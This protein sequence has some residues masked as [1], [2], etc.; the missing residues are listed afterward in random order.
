MT[1]SRRLVLA[2]GAIAATAVS[3]S[4][5][6][7]QPD[8]VLLDVVVENDKG[9]PVEGL[10]QNDFEI[11]SDGAVRPI[12][13]FAVNTPVCI[14]AVIDRSASVSM[15]V[16]AADE[17]LGDVVNWLADQ[18]RPSSLIRLGSLTRRLHLAQSYSLDRRA[19][20]A[21]ARNV[22]TMPAED[23]I[24]PT[25]VVDAIDGAVRELGGTDGRR[26]LVL[27]TDGRSAG[28]HLSAAEVRRRVAAG[29]AAVNIVIVPHA[30]YRAIDSMPKAKP[31]AAA[32]NP[33]ALLRPIVDASGGAMVAV[34]EHTTLGYVRSFE[35]IFTRL[36]RTY[37]L[38]IGSAADG[39]F[40][41]LTVHVK[42][43]GVRVTTR[44]G[45][46]AR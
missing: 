45:Y 25:P 20:L 46:Q 43:P 35:P 15:G 41:E 32:M 27:L 21:D 3:A 4:A 40:H 2:C 37:T 36:R 6:T 13:R 28:N 39:R 30:G 17:T 42:R 12:E 44:A 23:R 33:A 29:G 24:G 22:L 16:L 26:A 14:L 10:T 1:A 9:V 31:I 18:A 5:T 7:R 11:R 19:F 34:K 38:A 8:L